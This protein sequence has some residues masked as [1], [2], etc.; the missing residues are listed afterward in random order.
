MKAAKI[1]LMVTRF[2]KVAVPLAGILF[3]GFFAHG[4]FISG[5]FLFSVIS[6]VVGLAILF[7]SSHIYLEE[8]RNGRF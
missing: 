7:L 4:F 5:Y 6:A 1:T 2:I 8:T 3:C